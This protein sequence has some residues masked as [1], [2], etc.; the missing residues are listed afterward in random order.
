MTY[1][2]S[3]TQVRDQCDI[4]R[5]LCDETQRRRT[6]TRQTVKS[7]VSA[8]CQV[9][10]SLTWLSSGR[11]ALRV[12]ESSR[13]SVHKDAGTSR[14]CVQ[15]DFRQYSLMCDRVQA[16]CSSWTQSCQAQQSSSGLF[17]LGSRGKCTAVLLQVAATSSV[18]INLAMQ[19]IIAD[20]ED[21][22]SLLHM[23]QST[24]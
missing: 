21:S 6:L 17:G 22:D 16:L 20:T 8:K 7:T 12:N 9:I 3:G 1:K 11:V 4:V 18:T 5:H 15:N 2:I 10:A 23:A 19:I 14:A 24:K 13:S